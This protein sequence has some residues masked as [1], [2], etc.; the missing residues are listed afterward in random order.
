MSLQILL[1]LIKHTHVY[2]YVQIL[3]YQYVIYFH[4]YT[5]MLLYIYILLYYM[6]IAIRDFD[7]YQLTVLQTDVGLSVIYLIMLLFRQ[8]CKIVHTCIIGVNYEI[9]LTVYWLQL[10]SINILA[11]SSECLQALCDILSLHHYLIYH[12]FFL[13]NHF[14]FHTFQFYLHLSQGSMISIT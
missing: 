6:Q 5:Y 10:S 11:F 12:V 1:T 14:A 9:F 3:I 2:T 4:R 7:M 8:K 13:I